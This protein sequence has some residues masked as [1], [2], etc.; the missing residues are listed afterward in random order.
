MPQIVQ[1]RPARRVGADLGVV[2]EAAEG[3]LDNGI[4]ESLPGQRHEEAGIQRV[5][6]GLVS[7]HGVV[8]QCLPGGRV[9]RHQPR[10]PELR[11]PD[12]QHPT[13]PVDVGAVEVDHLTDPQT[14][15]REKP[16]HGDIGRCAQR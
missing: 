12:Q 9:H 4:R 6:L 11:F 13:V 14:G 7:H 10:L 1:P 15:D 8:A 16:D 3:V 2:D 5:R